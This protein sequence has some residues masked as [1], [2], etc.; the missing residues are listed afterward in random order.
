MARLLVQNSENEEQ[1]A[2]RIVLIYDRVQR[3]VY[4]F[5]AGDAGC[6]PADRI[7]HDPVEPPVIC[8]HD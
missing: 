8:T 3:Q 5:L 7:F 2:Q 4:V 1:A 6:D